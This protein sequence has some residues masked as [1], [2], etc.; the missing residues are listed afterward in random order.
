MFD[1]MGQM[2]RVTHGDTG[3]IRFRAG[4]RLELGENDC[5][6]FT[7]RRRKGGTVLE[8]VIAP[9]ENAFLM[10]FTHEETEIPADDYEWD[11]R[12]ILDAKKDET[13]RVTGGRE[14][15]TPFG[16]GLFRIERAV[17]NV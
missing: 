16:P 9:E 6:V 13:G 3:M 14:V 2:I 7:I 5:G 11:I 4:D 1:V 15:I 8:K 12:I 10:P 17:G